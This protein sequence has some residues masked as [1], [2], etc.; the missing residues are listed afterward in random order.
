MQ[1]DEPAYS[2][3]PPTALTRPE[4]QPTLIR[5]TTR[6]FDFLKDEVR[7]NAGRYAGLLVPIVVGRVIAAQQR[8]SSQLTRMRGTTFAL[9]WS[10]I[11]LTASYD[12][13]FAWRYRA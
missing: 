13:Y 4:R 11:C 3:P 7:P 2:P 8:F 5:R 9:A 10:L 12:A 1:S 6:L